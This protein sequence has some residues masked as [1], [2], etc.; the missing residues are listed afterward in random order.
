M[1]HGLLI[2]V[3]LYICR[4]FY[5]GCVNVYKVVDFCWIDPLMI[6]KCSFLSFVIAFVL[7]SVM[8]DV[9]LATPAFCFHLCEICF[10]SPCFQ[11]VCVF[12]SEVGLLEAACV[13]VLYFYSFSH[14]VSFDWN[15]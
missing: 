11:A 5:V 1:V 2:C 9:S 3:L 14:P 13:C 10:A 6:M 15:I 8:S 12:Q 4:C 7:M